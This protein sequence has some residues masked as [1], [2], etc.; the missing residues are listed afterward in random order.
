MTRLYK[1]SASGQRVTTNPPISR[2]KQPHFTATMRALLV[3][4]LISGLFGALPAAPSP[5]HAF[6]SALWLFETP[7]A[8][9]S[10][11]LEKQIE[12]FS[13]QYQLVS[14]TPVVIK[15]NHT[16]LDGLQAENITFTLIPTVLTSSCRVSG[17][18]VSLNFTTLLDG[19]LNYC[20]LYKLLAASGLTSDPGF[21]E[22]TNVW[23]CPG[24]GLS[25][26]TA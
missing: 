18:S 11:L 21:T 24:Y 5:Y 22:M 4:V 1:S 14:A 7:C 8:K 16:S 17:Q 15:A 12:D 9:I 6:C 3:C 26:C 10:F 2:R 20:N 25:S 23:A 13:P 19:G